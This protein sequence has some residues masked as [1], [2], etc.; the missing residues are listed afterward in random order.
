MRSPQSRN[1]ASKTRLARYTRRRKIT[2]IQYLN[3]FPLS[4]SQG[5]LCQKYDGFLISYQASTEKGSSGSP[6]FN[7]NFD[8]IGVHRGE[9]RSEYNIAID[10]FIL[11]KEFKWLR[12]SGTIKNSLSI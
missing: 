12:Q 2:V 9:S 7:E 3:G 8:V 1:M 4:Y 10:I 11:K 6:V 5:D